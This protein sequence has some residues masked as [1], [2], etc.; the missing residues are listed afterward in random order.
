MKRHLLPPIGL[1]ALICVMGVSQV[2][3]Q[4][5]GRG[6]MERFDTLDADSDGALS[7]TEA[8]EWR[9]AVFYAMDENEDERLTKEEYM[10]VRLGRG[11]DETQ[12]GPRSAQRQAEKAA[13]FDAMDPDGD[14]YVSQAQF[15]TEGE[16][17]FAKTDADNDGKVT[18]Q[19]FVAAHWM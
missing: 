10:S 13:V 7:A 2:I 8:T 5:G 1:A 9:T 15:M 6:M 17:E 12:R 16:R 3:A 4:G 18:L 11:A 19:E 14:G